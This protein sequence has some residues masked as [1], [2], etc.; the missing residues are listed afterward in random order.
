MSD[1]YRAPGE[2]P[3]A[4][5]GDE[6]EARALRAPAPGSREVE[7]PSGLVF[8]ARKI[9]G[10][11][12]AKLASK[13]EIDDLS[14]IVE[15]CC[16]RI[17]D[18]GPYALGKD[19]KVNWRRVLTGDVAV[20]FLRLRA[21]SLPASY[22][23]EIFKWRVTCGNENCIDE[24]VQSDGTQRRARHEFFWQVRLC[25][26]PLVKLSDGARDLVRRGNDSFPGKL[27]DGRAF[28]FK[29]PT[30]EDG[31]VVRQLLRESGISI[32]DTAVEHRTETLRPYLVAAATTS[33]EGVAA[34]RV[35][36]EV[37]DLDP[38]TIL[39]MHRQIGEPDGGVDSFK[40]KCDQCGTEPDLAFPF[41]PQLLLSLS[42]S[43]PRATKETNPL[44]GSSEAPR[45][46]STS[47]SPG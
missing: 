42:S 35:R 41:S 22:D 3:A 26:L 39:D 45:A 2:A 11:I 9:S 21:I 7:C 27:L 44:P 6:A 5:R 14:S 20:A 36:S 1:A 19:G 43:E 16:V 10:R 38:W 29:L 31:P 34:D 37:L 18:P 4:E 30:D 15:S 33:I 17:V 23:G 25:D 28:T 24:S 13:A 47:A 8:E 32:R 12:F 46:S 40:G